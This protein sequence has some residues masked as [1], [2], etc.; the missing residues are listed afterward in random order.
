MLF[1]CLVFSFLFFLLICLLILSIWDRLCSLL[2]AAALSFKYAS[3]CD[4]SNPNLVGK[5]SSHGHYR[6]SWWLVSGA[7][8]LTPE[9][10]ISLLFLEPQKEPAVV[11]K[12]TRPTT[13]RQISKSLAF[14]KKTNILISSI[15][16]LKKESVPI[17]LYNRCISTVHF[18][19]TFWP[20]NVRIR[21]QKIDAKSIVA[22]K[23]QS[24]NV[25]KG[26]RKGKEERKA[27]KMV[28]SSRMT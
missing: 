6:V 9:K 3:I 20:T 23:E 28:R 16:V 2:R 22:E 10:V 1:S 14:Q 4:L 17:A 15:L 8:S 5:F 27:A 26:T 25:E 7:H 18:P 24:D 21:Q 13:A 19:C 12:Q 11:A